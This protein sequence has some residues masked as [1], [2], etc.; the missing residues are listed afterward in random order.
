M[1]TF[2]AGLVMLALNHSALAQQVHIPSA[3][4][5]V[6]VEN[7]LVIG[8]KA[9]SKD[10]AERQVDLYDRDGRLLLGLAPLRFVPEAQSAGI[11]DVSGL[12][13][14]VVV[15]AAVFSKGDSFVPAASLLYFDF[16]GRLLLSL[17]LAPSREVKRVTVD[18]E[19]NV[20]TLTEG[21]GGQNPADVPMVVGYKLS[22]KPFKELFKRSEFPLHASLTQENADVGVPGFGHTSNRIW[23]WLPGSTDLVTFKPDGT[24]IKQETTSL[25]RESPHESTMKA[26]LTD[27]GS[28]VVEIIGDQ[29]P[30]R[31]RLG[32]FSKPASSARWKSFDATCVNPCL[33]VGVEKGTLLFAKGLGTGDLQIETGPIP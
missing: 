2:L 7:G 6:K 27:E 1:R 21:A 28:V 24:S 23:F 16:Q 5:A 8:W 33:L 31:G 17:A 19:S 15:V 32:F 25:P 20:W 14:Q 4:S 3:Y 29:N 18:T 11:S 10:P 26:L 9:T 30:G 12:P 13:G 22:G